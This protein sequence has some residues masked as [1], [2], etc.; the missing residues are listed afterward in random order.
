[1]I[2]LKGAHPRVLALVEIDRVVME[3]NSGTRGIWDSRRGQLFLHKIF[4]LMTVV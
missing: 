2:G 1:M 4:K 3:M